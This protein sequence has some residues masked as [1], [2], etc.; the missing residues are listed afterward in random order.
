MSFLRPAPTTTPLFPSF[1]LP[2]LPFRRR[3]SSTD[4]TSTTASTTSSLH[5][6]P[7]SPTST[8]HP[9]ALDPTSSPFLSGS[10]SFLRCGHCAV[11]LCLTTSIVSRGFTGRWGRAYLVSSSDSCTSAL[12]SAPAAGPGQLPNT[13]IHKAVPRQL[14]TGAHTVSD[15]S[16]AFCG[17]VLGWKYVGAEEESQQ[18]KVG[19]FILETKRVVVAT[20]WEVG[21]AEVE[22]G[23]GMG[24]GRGEDGVEFDSQDEDECEDLFAGTWT[25]EGARRRRARRVG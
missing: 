17:S 4:S 15:V 24:G 20:D 3:K 18:Y 21:F 16:C 13:H 23:V 2:T 9:P 5:S 10:K 8:L 7:L 22:E 11:D 6:P 1:L 14:V 12:S 25:V 19:K